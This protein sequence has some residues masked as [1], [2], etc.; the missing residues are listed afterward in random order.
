MK[1]LLINRKLK[2]QLLLEIPY[3]SF[4]W[5]TEWRFRLKECE[6]M[7]DMMEGIE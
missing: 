6:Y 1:Q 5:Y 7:I 3:M 2:I 4:E